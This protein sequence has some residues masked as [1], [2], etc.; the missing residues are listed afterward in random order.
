[1][2]ERFPCG[3]EKCGYSST[4]FNRLLSHIWNKHSLDSGFTHVCGVGFPRVNHLFQIFKVLEG[5]SQKSIVGFL[6]T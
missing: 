4:N 1:M 2:S 3:K 5:M 6:T